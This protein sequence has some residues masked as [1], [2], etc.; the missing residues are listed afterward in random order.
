MPLIKLPRVFVWSRKKKLYFKGSVSCIRNQSLL[1]YLWAENFWNLR[2]V[3]KPVCR[4]VVD[5]THSLANHFEL[6]FLISLYSP[7]PLPAL[8]SDLEVS[9][10]LLWF[11]HRV[12]LWRSVKMLRLDSGIFCTIGCNACMNSGYLFTSC[13]ETWTVQMN[14]DDRRCYS[15]S[16]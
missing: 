16:Y 10:S 5:A 14:V 3:W 11:A 4:P 15:K 12:K 1:S 6:W 9:H 7:I 13:S 8:D 2:S